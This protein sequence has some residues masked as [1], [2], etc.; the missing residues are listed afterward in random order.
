[1]SFQNIRKV[2]TADFYIDLAFRRGKQKAALVK[3][4]LQKANRVKKTRKPR[5]EIFVSVE[6]ERFR[7]VNHTLTGELSSILE[8]FPSIDA[9]PRFYLELVKCTIDYVQL[10]KSLG[11][12]DW[13]VKRLNSLLKI[14]NARLKGLNQFGTLKKTRREF[15]G[16]A[17]SVLKQIDS[18]LR[19]LEESRRI[20]RNFPSLHTEIPTVVIAGYPNVGKTTLL[21]AL[22]K[23]EPKI[24]PYPFTTQRLMLGYAVIGERKFQFIDTPGLLDRPL[25][26]RNRIEMQAILALRHLANF[27]MFI[28]DASESCGYG[29]EEQLKLLKEIKSSFKIPVI[30]LINKTDIKPFEV[31]NS[32]Q[33]SAEKNIGIDLVIEKIGSYL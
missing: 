24:A 5:I 3:Q 20:I 4:K 11:A 19:F 13:A 1:M 28:V 27:I 26:K 12:L 10:K 33:I 21:R 9:L 25:S 22:T 31:D 14:Y 32:I 29:V 16:R 15:Y 17:S 30:V 18:N 6:K 23:A 8:S 7:A 2:E